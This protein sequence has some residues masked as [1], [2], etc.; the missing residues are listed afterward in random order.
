MKSLR[1][2]TRTSKAEV[3]RYSTSGE[4]PTDRMI[5]ELKNKRGEIVSNLK[6]VASSV[7]GACVFAS[8]TVLPVMVFLWAIGFIIIN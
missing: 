8:Y 7:G 5:T 2:F 3:F 6:A 1:I 4:H